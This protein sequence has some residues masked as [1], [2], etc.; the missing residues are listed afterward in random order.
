MWRLLGAAFQVADRADAHI[1]ALGQLLLGQA[2]T[3]PELPQQLSKGGAQG[4][5]SYSFHHAPPDRVD[6]S[7][8]SVS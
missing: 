2:G 8:W 7:T 6:N 3:L 4:K 5:V 1:G